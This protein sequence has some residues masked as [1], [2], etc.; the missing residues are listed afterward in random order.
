MKNHKTQLSCT[1]YCNCEVLEGCFNPFLIKDNDLNIEMDNDDI[2]D[3]ES[4]EII[5][6]K[7]NIQILDLNV[8][9]FCV[10]E[11]KNLLIRTVKEIVNMVCL[12]I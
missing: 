6:N 1:A 5:W 9:I 2:S 8:Y 4:N 7:L 10:S 3:E 12:P 11:L